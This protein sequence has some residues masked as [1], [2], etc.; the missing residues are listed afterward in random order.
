MNTF[1][2]IH[3]FSVPLIAHV[4]GLGDETLKAQGEPANSTYIGQRLDLNP[5]PGGARQTW[6][7][8]LCMMQFT[9]KCEDASVCAYASNPLTC[10]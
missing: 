6:L 3:S 4:F 10:T 2:F 9:L 8:T 5:Q 1:P 7:M